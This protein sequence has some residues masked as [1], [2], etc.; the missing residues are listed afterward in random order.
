MYE[1][2]EIISRNQATTLIQRQHR[3]KGKLQ[4]STYTGDSMAQWLRALTANLKINGSNPDG[5]QKIILSKI[6]L[7]NIFLLYIH[8]TLFH[9]HTHTTLFW[10]WGG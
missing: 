6:V 8:I 7:S 4:V 1:V 9:I 2:Y 10:G 3:F 5:V